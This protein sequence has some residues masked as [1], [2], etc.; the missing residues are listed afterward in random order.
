MK[1]ILIISTL[2]ICVVISGCISSQPAGKST[3]QFSTSPEGAQIYLDNQYHGTT[4]STLSDVST[5]VHSLEFRYPGYQSWKANITVT[6]A[7]STY[8]AALAPLVSQTTAQ[9]TQEPVVTSASQPAVEILE[10]Q[11]IMIIGSS[12]TFYG[13]CT[14]SDTVILMLYGPGAYTNGIVVAMPSVGVDNSWSYTWNPGYSLMSGSYVMIAY[15]KQ[16]TT[17]DKAVFSVV[18]GGTVSIVTSN[19]V[20]SQGA[21]VTYSGLCTTGAKSVSL[22]LFGPGQYS[23]GLDVATLTLNADNTWSYKYKFDLTKPQGSYIM[24]VHDA[25]NTASDSVAITLMNG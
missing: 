18:G 25:Q 20:V 23:N 10:N 14:G 16:K 13:T 12:Q 2:I 8:S 6:A 4:P 5:G 7:S 9:S 3:L 1:R 17:S 19:Y 24:T 15:D 21:T 22:T 11:D